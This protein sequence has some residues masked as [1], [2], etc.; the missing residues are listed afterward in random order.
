MTAPLFERHRVIDID[1]H[2]TEPPDVFTSRVSSKWKTQ[3]P[4]VRNVEGRDLWF[5][6]DEMIGMP[7]AYSMAG[8]DG[9]PPDFRLAYAD[10]PASMIEP[11]ARLAF[12]D[13][14]NI[15]ANVL[16]PNIGGF[17]AQ[18]F[19]K[20]KDPELM[21]ECVRAYND[22]L[23]EWASADPARLVPVMSTPF[24]DI[25]ASVREIER[26]AALGFRAI[27][28]CNQ[29]QDFDMP[30]LR[31]KHWDPLWAAAESAGLS[32]SFHI[33][34]GD[35]SDL[36]DDKAEIG[37]KANFARASTLVFID[38]GRCLA[39]LIL[40]GICHRFP[41]LKMVSVE[42]GVGWIPFMLEALDWQW[43]NSGVIHEHPEWDLLPSEYFRRQIYGSFWFEEKG[44]SH[45]IEHYPDNI[46]YETDYP[47]P[48][49]M[50][51]GPASA[52]THPG[53]Y[54]EKV[55]EG[56]SETVIS[57]VLHDT[58]ADLYGLA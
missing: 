37:F 30:F 21:L 53:L 45:A 38:N 33:G 9:T 47:H 40:G 19:L 18:G 12:M 16:Y 46:L 28:M 23:L 58:A 8:H 2:V 11:K 29:P 52:G 56:L 1:T 13:E 24:W 3:V 51:P 25:A 14:E 10:I 17:G 5:I 55:L 48:T 4:H 35:L 42:S 20:L 31:D 41:K 36:L 6:G 32:I 26:C 57:K 7:G 15:Y 22:F 49:C 39:D 43:K 50:A 34:G 27:L 44:V 54:A